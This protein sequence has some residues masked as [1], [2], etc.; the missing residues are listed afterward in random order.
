[1]FLAW[2]F[3]KRS[4]PFFARK[5]ETVE[6]MVPWEENPED[7]LAAATSPQETRKAA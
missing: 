1:M 4:K 6:A 5:M 7:L 3:A 2:R